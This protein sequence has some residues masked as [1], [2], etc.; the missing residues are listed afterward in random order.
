M[1]ELDHKDHIEEL[2]DKQRA[3]VEVK[4]ANPSLGPKAL[5]EQASDELHGGE[6]VSRSYVGPILNNYQHLIDKRREQLDNE[7]YQGSEQ[8]VG[9]PF[10]D[11]L[12]QDGNGWQGIKERPTKETADNFVSVRVWQDDLESLL[13]GS[14]PDEFRDELLRELT[15][16]AFD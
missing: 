9:D 8:T 6:S 7:R 4:A 14:V 13:Q 5:A 1:A 3:V 12:E 2:T 10:E 15:A 16:K 11:T